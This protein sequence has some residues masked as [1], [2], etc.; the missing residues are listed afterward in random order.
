MKKLFHLILFIFFCSFQLSAQKLKRKA[1][2]GI[3]PQELNDS[4]AKAN[5]LATSTGVQV[6]EVLPNS[7]AEKLK[8]KPQDVI[9]AINKQAVAKLPDLLDPFQNF[10]ENEPITFSIAR[11]KKKLNLK[12]K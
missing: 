2:L 8:L 10:R 12:G 7:T 9:T 11:G 5:K 4:I 1:F 6:L 3:K